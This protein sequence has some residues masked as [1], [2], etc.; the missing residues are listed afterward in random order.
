MDLGSLELF[1]LQSKTSSVAALKNNTFQHSVFLD[2]HLSHQLHQVQLSKEFMTE[3]Q[4]QIH[5]VEAAANKIL[6][7]LFTRLIFLKKHLGP[8]LLGAVC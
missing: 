3:V 2:K 7:S 6:A 4:D 8:R 5:Q 1:S